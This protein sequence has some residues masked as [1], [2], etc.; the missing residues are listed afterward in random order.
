MF[1][2]SKETL[3]HCLTE[4]ARRGWKT[5]HRSGRTHNFSFTGSFVTNRSNTP[6]AK[7]RKRAGHQPL[8]STDIDLTMCNYIYNAIA[9]PLGEIISRHRDTAQNAPQKPKQPSFHTKQSSCARELHAADRPIHKPQPQPPAC[10]TP[11]RLFLGCRRS[12]ANQF[13]LVSGRHKQKRKAEPRHFF[14]GAKLAWGPD[15]GRRGGSSAPSM[16]R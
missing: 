5:A 6:P 10:H 13:P 4:A 3:L 9:Q 7:T 15:V 8:L 1:N 16:S 2:N 11:I 14:F 12:E